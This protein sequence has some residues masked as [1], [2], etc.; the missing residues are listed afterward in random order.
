[1]QREMQL[2]ILRNLNGEPK[3]PLLWNA[4]SIEDPFLVCDANANGKKEIKLSARVRSRPTFL[5]ATMTL[6]LSLLSPNTNLC[7]LCS[8][9]G[10]S[11]NSRISQ[12]PLKHFPPPSM[13]REGVTKSVHS[14]L[15]APQSFFLLLPFYGFN[16][17]P[18][19]S[20]PSGFRAPFFI[21]ISSSI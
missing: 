11:S 20:P 19:S 1:M 16:L 15:K 3:V 8:N 21:T 7:C 5:H 18:L 10:R 4:L 6:S 13:H 17:S 12:I 9:L 2:K 14:S